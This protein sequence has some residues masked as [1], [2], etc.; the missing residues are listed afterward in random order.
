[1]VRLDVVPIVVRHGSSSSCAAR[2]GQSRCWLARELHK[3]KDMFGGTG[4]LKLLYGGADARLASKHG[5]IQHRLVVT[6]SAGFRWI[7]PK[8]APVLLT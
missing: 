1:M 6:S 7:F 2:L 4:L 3:E 5:A 8:T